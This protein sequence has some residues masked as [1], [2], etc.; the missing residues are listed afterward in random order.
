MTHLFAVD[1]TPA[2]SMREQQFLAAVEAKAPAVDECRQALWDGLAT[3]DV[4]LTLK[5]SMKMLALAMFIRQEAHK[6]EGRAA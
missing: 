2:L 6:M 3:D 5:A 1:G 4:E